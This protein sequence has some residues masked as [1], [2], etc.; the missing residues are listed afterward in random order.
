MDKINVFDLH[1]VGWLKCYCVIRSRFQRPI[2]CPRE[3][4]PEIVGSKIETLVQH[5][6][7]H[8]SVKF[9]VVCQTINRAVCPRNTPFYNYRVALLNRYLSVVLETLPF[10]EFWR[11]KGLCKPNIPVLCKDG[12]HLNNKGQYALYRSYRGAILCAIIRHLLHKL[13]ST[14]AQPATPP[15]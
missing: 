2:D 4:K 9:I 10:A 7:A 15:A 13:T 3:V 12:V 1:V 14:A 5:L 6:H 8:F 11:H